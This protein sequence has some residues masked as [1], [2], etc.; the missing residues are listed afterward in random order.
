MINLIDIL[1][2]IVIV[3][4]I[5]SG[6]HRGFLLGMLDLVRWVGSLL[7]GLHFYPQVAAW[8]QHVVDWSE[9][10]LLPVSFILVT[11][12]ASIL[13]QSL[14]DLLLK[15]VPAHAHQTKENKV[16]GTVPG[17]FNGFITAAIIAILL[18]AFP[19]PEGME[20]SVQN[21]SLANRFA[22]YTEQIE[23]AAAPIFE[24]AAQRTLN[25]LTV[26]PGSDEFVELP[27]KVTDAKPRPDLEAQMLELLNEERVAEGLQPLEM[28]TAL[29]RVARL[30]SADMFSRGY[31][32]H[33]TPEG[34]DAFDRIRKGNVRFRTAGENLAL[35]PTLKIA[36][37]GLME[38]PGHRANILR[39]Q[40]GRVGIGV[41][42]GGRSQLMITQNFRN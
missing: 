6:W 8:L 13:I 34:A 3:A 41:L 18:M 9:L 7:L 28:D 29:T 20:R 39:R 24:K 10:W 42:E 36:H 38:S 31:F 5:V 27:Y 26:S 19:L 22:S 40:F 33:Y 4:S 21:S 30:H 23:T 35:A 2:V 17:L 25:K 32:S 37:E 1:F 14:G 16:F 12:V 11:I 15:R